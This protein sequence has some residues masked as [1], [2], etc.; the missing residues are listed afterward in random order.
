M[1]SVKVL[2]LFI[3][4][5]MMGPTLSIAPLFFVR[6]ARANEVSLSA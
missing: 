1:G 6:C 5:V 2:E 4:H 3:S